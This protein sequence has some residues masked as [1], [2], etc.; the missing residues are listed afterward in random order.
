MKIEQIIWR[1]RG[2]SKI[3]KTIWRH[4]WTVPHQN[5]TFGFWTLFEPFWAQQICRSQRNSYSILNFLAPE[6]AQKVLSKRSRHLPKNEPCFE[7]FLEQLNSVYYAN[8]YRMTNI[9]SQKGAQKVVTTGTHIPLLI[10]K[11]HFW[12]LD[13]FWAPFGLRIFVIL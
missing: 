10:E 2:G 1:R 13:T 11:L 3:R 12:L 4:M 7:H 8:S 5:F 9:L 6:S